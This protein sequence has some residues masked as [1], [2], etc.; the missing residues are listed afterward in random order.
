M[1]RLNSTSA[2]YKAS[3]KSQIQHK[4]SK[5]TQKQNIKQTKQ[6]QY[7]RTKAISKKY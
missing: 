6:K 4:N 1:C 2:H 7:D 5:N 3:A